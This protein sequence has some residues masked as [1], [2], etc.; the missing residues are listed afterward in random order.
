MTAHLAEFRPSAFAV[1]NRRNSLAAGAAEYDLL[2]LAGRGSFAEVWLAREQSTGGLFALKNLRDDLPN[3]QTARSLLENEAEAASRVHSEHVVQLVAAALDASPPYLVLEWL[4][5]ETL[6]ERLQREGPLV[7][8][9]T[10]WT[11]R[12]VAQGLADMLAA[13]LVHGDVKPSNIF[14]CRSGAVKLIDLAFV[15]PD[16]R[17]PDELIEPPAFTGTPDYLAPEALVPAEQQGIARD[18][19]ALGVTMYRM[20]A[21]QSPFHAEAVAETI[22]RQQQLHPP[23]L[24]S[25]APHVAPEIEDLVHRLLSKQPVRRGENIRRLIR[26]LIGLE[27]AE[28]AD[29]ASGA[30]SAH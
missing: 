20:L 15:R 3:P 13:G 29:L 30:A 26:E 27:L 2:S 23:R 25:L 5:G 28:L 21:G 11:A 6:E 10:L 7:A 12:Q 24:R 8:G 1:R 14:I 9:Q 22:R 17:P 19:Y 16:R 18:L 4:S